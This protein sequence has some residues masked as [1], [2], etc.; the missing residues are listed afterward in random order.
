MEILGGI[1]PRGFKQLAWWGYNSHVLLVAVPG[2][3]HTSWFFIILCF[4]VMVTITMS[5]GW[6]LTVCQVLHMHLVTTT[7]LKMGHIILILQ[8]KVPHSVRLSNLS[9]QP[10]SDRS[11]TSVYRGGWRAHGL[12]TYSFHHITLPFQGEQSC[13]YQNGQHILSHI[14]LQ[15]I[16][17][18]LVTKILKPR[19]RL[20]IL[21]CNRSGLVPR[22]SFS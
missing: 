16:E 20:Q 1:R 5:F 3:L 19:P 13:H 4:L 18:W 14:C 9:L 6:A 12:S 11:G 22:E 21:W 15:F 17:R 2:P 10:V 7:I 8:M